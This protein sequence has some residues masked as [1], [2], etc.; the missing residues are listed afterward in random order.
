[1]KKIFTILLITTSCFGLVIVFV[2]KYAFK[3]QTPLPIYCT[4]AFKKAIKEVEKTG[5]EAGIITK[6]SENEKWIPILPE[7]STKKN[8]IIFDRVCVWAVTLKSKTTIG[9]NIYPDVAITEIQFADEKELEASK[10]KIESY[11]KAL[12]EG[13]TLNNFWQHK[14]NIYLLQTRAFL[15]EGFYANVN[16]CFKKS[17]KN[18]K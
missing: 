17:I 3:T 1:M 4:E 12:I 2:N 11:S 6:H 16:A 9:A 13:K 5:Y 7:G 10:F 14:Q 18:Q 15:F 8:K